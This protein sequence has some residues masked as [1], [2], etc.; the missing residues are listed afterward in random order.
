MS[1]LGHL[2]SVELRDVWPN[3]AAD[4]TPWLAEEEN[5]NLLAESL[6]L[7][8]ELAGQE[9]NVGPFRADI[10]CKNTMD[11]SWVVIE[12]QLDKTDHWHL[13]QILT[14]SAGLDAHTVIWIS[15]AFQDEH[16][17][18]LDRL[19]E[20]TNERFRYFG[21]EIKLW[22]IGNSTPAPQF[23]IVSNPNDWTRTVNQSTQLVE[24]KDLSETQLLR[25]KYWTAF[26]DYLIQT[27]S[28]VQCP[29]LGP[30]SFVST[31]VEG[32]A[33]SME[34]WLSQKNKEIGIRRYTEGKNA[35]AYFHL[36]MEQ[37]QEIE[38]EV[39]ESLE[40]AEMPTKKSSRISL[41]KSD[42]D[43]ADETDWPNQHAWIASTVGKFDKVLRPRI[44]ALNPADWEPPEDEDDE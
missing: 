31:S 40:W 13:G 3:E 27:G 6:G 24:D 10:L 43:P 35:K 14:Y 9:V 22:Q 16:R 44:R 23:E 30:W 1:K 37:K 28:S 34:V 32:T 38:E 12:N 19:N 42:I 21:V 25:K 29:K 4:F 26:R 8:L 20:I 36:L 7:E 33:F 2:Q 15:R 11:N 41:C 5:L 39:G 18:A 17:A